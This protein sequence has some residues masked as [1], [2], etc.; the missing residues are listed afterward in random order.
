ME[1][2]KIVFPFETL[3][4]IKVTDQSLLVLMVKMFYS[5]ISWFYSSFLLFANGIGRYKRIDSIDVVMMMMM[6]CA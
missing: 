4:F 2:I 6:M 1:K 3:Q 5:N